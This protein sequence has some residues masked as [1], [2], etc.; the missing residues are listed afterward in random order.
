MGV[1]SAQVIYSDTVRWELSLLHIILEIC[2]YVYIINLA[3]FNA[4]LM[5]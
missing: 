4:L 5:C 2:I 3:N 1:L